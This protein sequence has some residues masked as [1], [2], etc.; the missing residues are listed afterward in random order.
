MEAKKHPNVT[1]KPRMPAFPLSRLFPNM[2]TLA[3]LCIGISSIRFALDER[4]EMAVSFIIIAAF[5]DGMDGRL[6]RLLNATSNF[7]AQ[8]DSLS[9]FVCFGLSPAI[10]LYLWQLQTIPVKRVAWALVLFY[11]VCSAIRLAR[12]NSSMDEDGPEWREQFFT[13]IPMP[14]GAIL[15]LTPMML[16]FQSDIA[17]FSNNWVLGVY[18]AFIALMMAGRV[19]TF[20]LKKIVVQPEFVSLVMMVTGIIIALIILDPWLILSIVSAGYW[21]L[22][23][24]AAYRHRQ[25][26]LQEGA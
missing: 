2:L 17:L 18:F 14:A 1:R 19:P 13:G 26:R 4:W 23:P 20:S 15:A 25:L 11:I 16:S 21:V 12:F 24:I 6:A 10:L 9:D 22:I 8:L 7:G 5:V 3:G